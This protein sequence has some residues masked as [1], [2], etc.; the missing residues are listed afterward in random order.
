[1][2]ID[3][4]CI[5]IEK[6]HFEGIGIALQETRHCH[7][8]KLAPVPNFMCG[9]F[10]KQPYLQKRLYRIRYVHYLK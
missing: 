1:M 5:L 4:S 3:G 10:C 2:H 8:Q 6:N 9:R 7:V